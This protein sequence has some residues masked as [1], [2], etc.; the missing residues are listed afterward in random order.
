MVPRVR[1][2]KWER[3]RR[4][5]FAIR[6]TRERGSTGQG[7]CAPA[8]FPRPQRFRGPSSQRALR[9]S[10]A[11]PSRGWIAW[12]S[13]RQQHSLHVPHAVAGACVAKC[14]WLDFF[15]CVRHQHGRAQPHRSRARRQSRAGPRASRGSRLGWCPWPPASGY[16]RRLAWEIGA[17]ETRDHTRSQASLL[18]VGSSS[19]PIIGK[20]ERCYGCHESPRGM[21]MHS[22]VA[23]IRVC[24]QNRRGGAAP[25]TCGRCVMQRTCCPV[26][27]S[28]SSAAPTCASSSGR[29]RAKRSSTK[30]GNRFGQRLR[31][32]RTQA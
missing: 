3:R 20:I 9:T 19:A 26:R 1:A 2:G 23:V 16:P 27:A 24:G 28:R 22:G 25:A 17:A 6:E 8:A 30:H 5:E 15:L 31:R 29:G 4:S 21:L 13:N 10:G 12:V 32:R 18:N 7:L 11:T 14:S